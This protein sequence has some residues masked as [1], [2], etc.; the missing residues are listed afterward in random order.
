MLE[1]SHPA[2][3]V[4]SLSW[5]VPADG[6]LS[7]IPPERTGFDPQNIHLVDGQDRLLMVDT[8]MPIHLD[9]IVDAV[10][11]IR[12]GRRLVVFLTRIELECLSNLPGLLGRMDNVE[13]ATAVPLSPWDLVHLPRAELATT[14]RVTHLAFGG[15]LG[16][17]GF[18]AIRIL[19]P[20]VNTLST[21][22]LHDG[23][24]G[25]LFSS[26]FFAA[27]IAP[28]AATP[29]MRID[30]DGLP[31]PDTIGRTVLHKFDW[32]ARARREPLAAAYDA[33]FC[34]V[35]PTALCPTHGRIA[36]GSQLCA[37]IVDDHRQ[38]LFARRVATQAA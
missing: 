34:D 6:R 23:A 20:P 5:T 28:D 10:E 35:A 7:W 8:G 32:L 26:D 15:T 30:G 38:A 31:D 36:S 17:V 11:A 21:S 19:R 12:G 3:G 29:A 25:A 27:D 22:W 33:L 37:R 16:E 13:V 4:T 14:V 24:S 18:P 2:H 1:T 9:A